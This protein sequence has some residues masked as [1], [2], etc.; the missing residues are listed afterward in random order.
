M[1]L[2]FLTILMSLFFLSKRLLAVCFTVFTGLS[3]FT[4]FIYLFEPII[5]DLIGFKYLYD[6]FNEFLNV[7]LWL[8]FVGMIIAGSR[9][10]YRDKDHFDIE[11]E[12]DS[13]P[14]NTYAN[15]LERLCWDFE[16]EYLE[17]MD[18]P[19]Y[20]DEYFKSLSPKKRSENLFNQKV[21]KI[22]TTLIYISAASLLNYLGNSQLFFI[23]IWNSCICFYVFNLS[24][25]VLLCL[26]RQI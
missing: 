25:V 3:F 21:E 22:K 15:V 26:C 4:L 2:T 23:L 7:I 20:K 11:T 8:M 9:G 12:V 6:G 1:F 17:Y 18:W 10:E 16:D 5:L 19:G 24:S 14:E 13:T